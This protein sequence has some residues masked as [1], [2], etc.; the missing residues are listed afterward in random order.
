MGMI[1]IGA[2]LRDGVFIG[3]G[4]A[5]LDAGEG[6]ARHAVHVERHKK[7]VPM[8]GRILFE[9]VLDAERHLFAFTKA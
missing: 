3:E 2:R 8:D 9:H 4:L 7:S 1:P 5:R 6:D